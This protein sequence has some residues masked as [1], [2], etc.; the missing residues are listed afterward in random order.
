MTVQALDHY[1]IHTSNLDASV[2]FYVDVLGLRNGERPAF[3]IPGAWLYLGDV[4]A[5]HLIGGDAR[6]DT[7]TGAIDHIAFRA[8]GLAEFTDHLRQLGIPFE[9]RTPPGTRMRQVFVKDPDGLTVEVN[10]PGEA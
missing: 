7:G 3:T 5:V 1:T 2:A 4:P 10:F 8:S 6:K 9:E